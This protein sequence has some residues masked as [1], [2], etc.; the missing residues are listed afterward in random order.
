MP[1]AWMSVF[2]ADSLSYRMI[3]RS[4]SV[5]SAPEMPAEPHVAAAD[6]AAERDDVDLLLLDLALAHQRPDTRRHADRRRAAG[7]ELRV[8]PGNDPRR[9]HVARVRHVHAA[10]RA[11]GDRARR[12]P[13]W[14]S[15]ASPAPT[16]SPD[17]CGGPRCTSPR[18]ASPRMPLDLVVVGVRCY[19]MPWACTSL[20]SNSR[21]PIQVTNPSS[22]SVCLAACSVISNIL[23][24][25]GDRDVAAAQARDEVSR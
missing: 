25:V 6:V 16:R 13:P 15:R 3:S 2:A 19:R 5:C 22:F 14:R 23:C 10:G 17:R 8:H 18:A 11:G 9:G 12:R 21:T 20:R 4:R 1:V 24:A 7:A